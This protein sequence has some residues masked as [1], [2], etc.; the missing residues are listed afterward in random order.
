MQ[1]HAVRR[2]ELTC[3]P[4]KQN[5]LSMPQSSVKKE[6]VAS[7]VLSGHNDVREV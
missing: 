6:G 3:G 2:V 4:D 5:G 1:R 7:R